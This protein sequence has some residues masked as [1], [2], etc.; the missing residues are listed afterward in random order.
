M[1]QAYR[2]DGITPPAGNYPEIES[3]DLSYL[4]DTPNFS[5]KVRLSSN[6]QGIPHHDLIGPPP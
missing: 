1:K 4:Q 2:E 6:D 5:E 3:W